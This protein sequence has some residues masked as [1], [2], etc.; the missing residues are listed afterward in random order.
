MISNLSEQLA[1][2]KL[3]CSC[4]FLLCS[5]LSGERCSASFVFKC[6]LE[7]CVSLPQIEEE[8]TAT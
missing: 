4:A 7:M 8:E 6:Q 5:E 3:T 1:G 2:E